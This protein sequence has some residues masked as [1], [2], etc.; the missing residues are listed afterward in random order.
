MCG[1]VGFIVNKKKSRSLLKE[2]VLRMSESLVHRGPDGAGS[3]VDEKEGVG[4][5]HRRLSIIDLSSNGDQPMLSSSRQFILSYNGEI[6]NFSDLRK[7]L[8]RHQ[9]TFRGHSDTE[10]ILAAIEQWGLEEAL[11]RFVGMFA[12]ALWDRKK[13]ELHLVRDRMGEKPVYYGWANDTFL[14]GSELKALRAH[15]DWNGTID[16][17]SLA[18]QLRYNHIPTPFSIFEGIHK[19][20]PGMILRLNSGDREPEIRPFWSMKNVVESG[21]TNPFTGNLRNAISEFDKLFRLSVNEKMIGDVPIGAFLSGG[22][23]S[24][25]VVAFMQAQSS[26]PIKT[27]T[28][29][30]NDQRYDEAQNAKAIAQYLHTDHTDLY[31]SPED[32][33]K[34]IPDLPTLFDEPFSDSSQIPTYLV[35]RL[36][37]ASVTVALSGDGADEIFSGYHRY[38]SGRWIWESMRWIPSSIRSLIAKGIMFASSNS[39]N[40]GVGKLQQL[41]QPNFHVRN[42]GDKL[43][44]LADVIAYDGREGLY[45]TLLAQR[46]FPSSP[47]LG[48]AESSITPKDLWQDSWSFS[49]YSQYM[50]FM[51]TIGSLPDDM[52][53]KVDRASMGG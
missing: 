1:I 10:I 42:T 49:N 19:L 46:E 21:L 11:S 24:S 22:I 39:W 35:S 28:I 16:R 48:G 8:E 3:W 40:Q 41:F 53:T 38:I 45:K 9:I 7:E 29:G 27:F 23:D 32:A 14:F 31:V 43:Q 15:P 52:L 12:F 50:M 51:D 6:Y 20:P 13:K 26:R 37:R 5:G 17:D 33:M 34:V 18:L 4:L 44:K 30:F 47:I 36:A 25:L 2:D